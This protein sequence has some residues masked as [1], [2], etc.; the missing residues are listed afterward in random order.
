MAKGPKTQ[1]KADPVCPPGHV[2][3]RRQAAVA[4]G[5][6][7][8]TI[9]RWIGQGAPPPRTI[10][11]CRLAA[12]PVDAIAEWRSH[13]IA[14][15]MLADAGVVDGPV[16]DLA[17]AILRK[18]MAEAQLKEHELAVRQG[19]FVPV[20][21]VERAVI[22]CAR[23]FI[24]ILDRAAAELAALL[25]GHEEREFVDLVRRWSNE[26]RLELLDNI[27]GRRGD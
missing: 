6:S 16:G 11:G 4:L 3:G 26:R 25:A 24:G 9:R 23:L 22:Q 17:R 19:K 20:D 7:E 5:V 1:T 12:Y 21:H 14:G 8:E 10:P 15:S 2:L 18:T 13:Q 27:H